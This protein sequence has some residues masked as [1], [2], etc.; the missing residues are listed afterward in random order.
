MYPILWQIGRLNIYTH[1]VMIA[2]GAIVGGIVLY[3][4]AKSK[5]FK[6]DF[7]FDLIVFSLFGGIIGARILYI[8]IY[9]NQFENIK[10]MLS[11]WNGGLVSFGGIIGGLLVA[12][13]YLRYKKENILQWLDMGIIGLMVGWSFGRIG[14][15]LNG[16]S[17]GI[18]SISKLA[19]WGR[20]PTQLFESFWAIIVAAMCYFGLKLKDKWRLPDGV[21]F[22]SSIGLY[23][24][25][26]FIVDFWRDESQFFWF[27]KTGQFGSLIIF[28]S[29]VIAILILIKNNKGPDDSN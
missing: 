20:V 27:L 19:I 24:L 14:C 4:I 22:I 7:I 10:D 12:F 21:I 29:A 9:F 6:T 5:D 16:D 17:F 1:G 15:L 26:R 18:I 23:C 2:A 28:L 3:Y 11:I 25:G 13:W 8:L